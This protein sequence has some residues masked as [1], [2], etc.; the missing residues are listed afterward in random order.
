MCVCV[1]LCLRLLVEF[2]WKEPHILFWNFLLLIAFVFFV[3]ARFLLRLHVDCSAIGSSKALSICTHF[4]FER[5]P[6]CTNKYEHSI[7]IK[8]MHLIDLADGY[9]YLQLN[10]FSIACMCQIFCVRLFYF[11]FFRPSVSLIPVTFFLQESQMFNLFYFS[12]WK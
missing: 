1:V 6:L 5:K 11:V 3:S 2:S 8:Y 9:Y 7:D 4:V 10:L 12:N